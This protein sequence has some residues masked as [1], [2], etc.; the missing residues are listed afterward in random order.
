LVLLLA[1]IRPAWADGTAGDAARLRAL[2]AELTPILEAVAGQRFRTP[3]VVR[4]VS[5][6]KLERTLARELERQYAP[7]LPDR[8]PEEVRAAMASAAAAMSG[9][10]VAKYAL[11]E[12]EVWVVPENV[13]DLA[14]L[15]ALPSLRS[16][17]VLRVML[18]H[19]L[20]HALDDQVY[21]LR[22]LLEGA[23]TFDQLQIHIAIVEGHAQFMAARVADRLGRRDA[24]ADFER[25]ILYLRWEEG[26][27]GLNFVQRQF[28]A[29]IRF[30]YVEGRKFF[31]ALAAKGGLEAEARVFAQ[32][33][34]EADQILQPERYGQPADGGKGVVLPTVDVGPVLEVFEAYHDPQVWRFQ[35][36]RPHK[37]QF[38]EALSLL[39]AER[40]KALLAPLRQA[41]TLIGHTEGSTAHFCSVLEFADAEAA[42]AFYQAEAD[43]IEAKRARFRTGS[44]VITGVQTTPLTV[45][46]KV[47]AGQIV[48][49][50]MANGKPQ[51]A[52]NVLLC[53]DRFLLELLFSGAD[54]QPPAPAALLQLA[55]RLIAAL[56]EAAAADR[57]EPE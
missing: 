9:F 27:E 55:R 20:A 41:T 42:T 50:L 12:R 22:P 26:E 34:Q 1:L 2:A 32:P 44:L 45:G 23:K 25:A 13:D 4:T 36:W 17:A 40:V 48:V 54:P 52:I 46:E 33:P 14:D 19:E 53:Q 7:L 10:L 15:L 3:P 57:D 6:A 16:E 29:T 35:C 28:Q 5:R 11:D 18:A 43:V 47:T 37:L 49:D 30:T 21:S 39:P 56:E 24:F 8:T 51:Q 31:E 38:H